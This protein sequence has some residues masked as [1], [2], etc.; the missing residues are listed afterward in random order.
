MDHDPTPLDLR[1]LPHW[2]AATRRLDDERYAAARRPLTLKRVAASLWPGIRRPLFVLGAPRSGTSFLGDALGG[3]ACFSYHYEPPLTKAAARYVFCGLWGGRRARLTY[4]LTYRWLLGRHL[5]GDL[6]FAEKTPQNCFVVD[7]LAATF[8]DAQ[9]V[10]IVRDGRDAA[11]SYRD[12]PWLRADAA[13]SGR[14][15]AGGYRHGPFARFWVEPERQGEFE[16]TTDLHRCIW[17]WRRHVEAARGAGA[18]LPRERFLEVRYEALCR[19]A[20][21]ECARLVRFLGLDGDLSRRFDGALLERLAAASPRSVGRHRAE[22]PRLAAAERALVEGE[23]AAL[24]GAL[25]YL[26]AAP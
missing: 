15:E 10:H 4:R 18:R 11:L 9:F 22:W 24:L 16:S 21:G 14:R 26:E 1:T 3:L 2:I 6:R 12:K 19:D 20:P 8:P 7:F 23:A 5:A 17:A 13:A 25:G